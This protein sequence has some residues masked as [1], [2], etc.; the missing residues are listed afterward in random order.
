MVGYLGLFHTVP[1]HMCSCRTLRG[2]PAVVADVVRHLTLFIP[3]HLCAMGLRHIG[4][5]PCAFSHT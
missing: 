4:Q 2:L 5:G 1:R 3:R